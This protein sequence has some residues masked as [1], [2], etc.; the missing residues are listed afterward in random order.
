VTYSSVFDPNNQAVGYVADPG[1]N[2]LDLDLVWS[3]ILPAGNS[4]QLVYEQVSND[5]DPAGCTFETC[6]D[7]A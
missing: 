1:A 7:Y 2:D 6:I 4:F 5:T 3:F